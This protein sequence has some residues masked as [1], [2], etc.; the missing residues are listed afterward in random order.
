MQK[1]KLPDFFR[2]EKIDGKWWFVDPEGYLFLSAGV[3]CIRPGSGT[4]T[5]FVDKRKGIYEELPPKELGLLKNNTSYGNWNLLRRYGEDWPKKSND[6]VFKRMDAWGINTIANWSDKGVISRNKKPF[7]LQLYNLEIGGGIMGLPNVYAP[8][9]ASNIEKSVKQQVAE[10]ANN[11]WL[12]GWFTGNEPAWIGEEIRLSGLIQEKGD[13][14]FKGAINKYL[15]SGD[16]P[17]KRKQFIY[18]TL[19]I[20]LETVDNALEK[21][22]PNHLHIGSRFGGGEAPAI[23]I[24][25]ICKDVYDVYSFN[26]YSLMPGKEYMDNVYGR[27]GLPMIIG[28][29]HFGTVDRG[30]A[31]SLWQVD[32]QKERGVAYRY[33]VENG[34][35]HPALIGT[36]YFQWAD[37]STTGRT[38]DGENYNCGLIDVTDLPYKYQVE[39]MVKTAKRLFKIHS[40]ELKPVTKMP[41]RARGY[42]AIPDGWNK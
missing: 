9:F 35:A 13:S 20:F 15:A 18:R 17:E 37:Q 19:R 31:Q 5:K 1:P 22:D 28:E 2:T 7:M 14:Y 24:L 40:G 38:N 29:Y 32:N 11:P 6:M 16:S 39:A 12:I 10:Y 23:E 30:M 27:T 3:D 34:Y 36:A 33:Y 25:D 21:Y 26:S 41:K 42:G 8:D 4:Q